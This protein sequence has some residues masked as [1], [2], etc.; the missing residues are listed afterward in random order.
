VPAMADVAASK[1]AVASTAP[2][3]VC[4]IFFMN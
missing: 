1:P 3:M 2:I 4:V